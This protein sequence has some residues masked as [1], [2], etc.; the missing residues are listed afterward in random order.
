MQQRSPT[1][2]HLQWL[3]VIIVLLATIFACFIERKFDVLWSM[4]TLCFGYYFGSAQSN[5][6][7][8]SA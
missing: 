3:L 8:R 1:S 5:P 6:P 2:E 7:T 4:C